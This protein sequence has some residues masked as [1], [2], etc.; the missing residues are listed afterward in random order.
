MS[1]V[2]SPSKNAWKKAVKPTAQINTDQ[3]KGKLTQLSSTLW[4]L[5]L[6]D[7]L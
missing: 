3:E 1:A 6:F 2:F 5:L 4:D 7:L